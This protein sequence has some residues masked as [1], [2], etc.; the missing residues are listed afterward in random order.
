M[1]DDRYGTRERLGQGQTARLGHEHVG[2]AHQLGHVVDEAHRQHRRAAP[3]LLD[4]PPEL[5]ISPAHDQ[6]LEVPIDQ[7]EPGDVLERP[8]R[9]FSA[10]HRQHGET[11]RVESELAQAPFAS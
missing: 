5:G 1:D 9:A 11:R 8:R 7:H 10:N 3:E 2:G 4:L 6:Q